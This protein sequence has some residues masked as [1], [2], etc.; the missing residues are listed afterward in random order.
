MRVSLDQRELQDLVRRFLQDAAPPEYLR[1]RIASGLRSDP[2]LWEALKQLG[3]DD[4]FTSEEGG[5]SCADLGLVA[6]EVG[7]ALLPEPLT[8]RLFGDGIVSRYLSPAT[9]GVL[10]DVEGGTAFAPSACCRLKL[11]GRSKKISGEIL[12]AFGVEGANRLIGSVEHGGALKLFVCSL[13]QSGIRSGVVPSLDLT[14]SLRSLSLKDVAVVLLSDE[15]SSV[16]SDIFEILK[17]SEVYGVT[18]RVV[19]MSSEY[20]KTREQFGVP[21][22]AFQALQ[23]KLADAYAHSESLGALC[24]FA[25]WS[26]QNSPSQRALTARAAIAQAVDVGPAVCEVAIQV[27]GGIGFTWEY[28]LHLFLR[29]AKGLQ[30]AFLMTGE[31]VAELLE[32]A[33]VEG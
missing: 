3:L 10:K 4:G 2:A 15:E 22:G 17:A 27:H 32:R 31:R 14:T 26:V 30:S 16:V 7:R 24:R 1:K 6:E 29:R 33:Q 20:L 12:W 23:Q 8:E 9:R 18:S 11:N 28:D 21:I 13:K 19:E 25:A 5:L